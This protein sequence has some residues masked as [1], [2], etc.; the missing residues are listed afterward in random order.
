MKI[1]YLFQYSNINRTIIDNDI[2]VGNKKSCALN[3]K[4]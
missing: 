3:I 1:T 2:H 4:R